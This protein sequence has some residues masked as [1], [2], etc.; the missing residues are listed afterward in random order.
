LPILERHQNTNGTISALLLAA[1]FHPQAGEMLERAAVVAKFTGD[2]AQITKVLERQAAHLALTDRKRAAD[3]TRQCLEAYERLGD[4]GGQ[5]ACLFSLAISPGS[6]AEKRRVALRAAELY[7]SL[8]DFG[9][10]YKSMTMALMN[11]NGV[12]LADQLSYAKAGLKDA[13]AYGKH[14][15][16]QFFYH[17]LA[18]IHAGLGNKEEAEKYHRWEQSI[19]ESDGLTPK[20]RQR[21]QAKS[22]KYFD[23]LMKKIGL[24]KPEE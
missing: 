8:E 2:E 12:S 4:L 15:S 16:E 14:S 10:A 21:E 5:A 19:V 13:Q 23:R 20:Q 17:H 1:P 24:S 9:Q 18:R 3:L 11:C 6:D 7:R 22:N